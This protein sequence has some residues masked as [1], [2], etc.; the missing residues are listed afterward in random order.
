MKG[1]ISSVSM[2]TGYDTMVAVTVTVKI[3][4]REWVKGD[5]DRYAD[6]EIHR[7]PLPT[8]PSTARDALDMS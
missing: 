1:S 5:L 7:A 6:V 3:P 8:A 4:Y 2:P